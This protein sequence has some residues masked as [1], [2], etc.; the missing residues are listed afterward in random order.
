MKLFLGKKQY[1]DTQ[2]MEN[3]LDFSKINDIR[4][5]L[6]WILDSHKNQEGNDKL[7]WYLTDLL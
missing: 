6:G 1:W 4:V 3:K 7:I 2:Q 5:K